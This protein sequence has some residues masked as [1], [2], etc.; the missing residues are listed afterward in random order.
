MPASIALIRPPQRRRTASRR[1]RRAAKNAT[2][3]PSVEANDASRV[4]QNNPNIAPPATL[5]TITPGMDKPVTVAYKPKYSKAER[6]G[7][8]R[9]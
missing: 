7:C 2:V 1:K 5:K 8:S 9:R 6:R 3:P 4:P